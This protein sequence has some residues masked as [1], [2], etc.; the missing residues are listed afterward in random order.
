TAGCGSDDHHAGYHRHR[1]RRRIV[2]S[3]FL[4]AH[5]ESQRAVRPLNQSSR[6][7][8]T[9]VYSRARRKDVLLQYTQELVANEGNSTVHRRCSSS[10][11]RGTDGNFHI[12]R[13][14]RIHAKL[15]YTFHR[16]ASR[17]SDC[18]CCARSR[19]SFRTRARTSGFKRDFSCSSA[20]TA[21][22]TT[23]LSSIDNSLQQDLSP[24][25]LDGE[26]LNRCWR[27]PLSKRNVRIM[28]DLKKSKRTS[29]RERRCEQQERGQGP[30]TKRLFQTR[31]LELFFLLLMAMAVMVIHWRCWWWC[32][33]R[34]LL[35][36]VAVSN[37][38]I[39]QK[40]IG[41]RF[42][43]NGQFK[44]QVSLQLISGHGCTHH[45]CGGSILDERHIITAAHCVTDQNSHQFNGVY[46]TVVAD[47]TYLADKR[48]G[49]Y[50]DVEYTFMPYS[51]MLNGAGSLS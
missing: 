10:S 37:G 26:H 12:L 2:L 6:A 33:S 39:V 38:K 46:I 17:C 4:R 16:I 14:P 50:H 25:L 41:G 1:H 3:N 31:E 34:R 24:P 28:Y 44:Y 22:T 5:A 30:S 21:T 7:N 19:N 11:I 49:L 51:Y 40:I 13:F 23:A 35:L 27:T 9:Y 42:A 47:A 18:C 32:L 20:A 43:S 8:V 15:I 45:F 29:A 36:S 48:T